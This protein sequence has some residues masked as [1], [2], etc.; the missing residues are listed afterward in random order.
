MPWIDLAMDVAIGI[1][2]NL[3]TGI[4]FSKTA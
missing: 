1:Q 2:T 3:V 4:R